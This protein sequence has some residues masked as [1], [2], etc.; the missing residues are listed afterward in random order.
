VTT[1]GSSP[2]THA[3]SEPYPREWFS[4]TTLSRLQGF[5]KTVLNTQKPDLAKCPCN[6]G[7]PNP[8]LAVVGVHI[9]GVLIG[10]WLHRENLIGA[11]IDGRRRWQA[12]KGESRSWRFA[13]S[14]VLLV[15]LAAW[16]IRWQ[17]IDLNTG[18]T[19]K[20]AVAVIGRLHDHDQE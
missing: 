4:T 7:K 19:G 6:R 3:G 12:R 9:A 8:L 2:Q 20:P 15:A 17:G 10:S 5:R 1:P 13:A 16:W 18:L 14:M 11:M